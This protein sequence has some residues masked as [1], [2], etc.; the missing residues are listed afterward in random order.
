MFGSFPF[1]EKIS[2]LDN[3]DEVLN[4]RLLEIKNMSKLICDKEQ[5]KY[6]SY[7]YNEC[8]REYI[9]SIP[10]NERM[11]KTSNY[12]TK[13]P[14]RKAYENILPTSCLVRPQTMAFDGSGIYNRIKELCSEVLDNEFI[15]AKNK[16]FNFNSKMEYYLF[17]EYLK[18]NSYN[19]SLYNQCPHCLSNMKNH[20]MCCDVCSSI[21]INGKELKFNG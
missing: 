7:Y 12:K 13:Y 15:D 14:L 9:L 5:I 16:Y 3:L 11:K 17:K 21:K 18:N 4:Q 10:I 8:L 1:F 20:V 2:K 19:K 6:I